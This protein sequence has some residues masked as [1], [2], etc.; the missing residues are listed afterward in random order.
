MVR[1]KKN[2]TERTA[3]PAQTGALVLGAAQARRAGLRKLAVRLI[4]MADETE[5]GVLTCQ[6]AA[7]E[8]EDAFDAPGS[9]EKKRKAVLAPVVKAFAWTRGGVA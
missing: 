4:T 5:I 8:I 2:T 3:T 9:D 1:A 7:T 6:M